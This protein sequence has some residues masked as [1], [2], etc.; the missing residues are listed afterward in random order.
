MKII[1]S[2]ALSIGLLAMLAM[3]ALAFD[4]SGTITTGGTAQ[5]VSLSSSSR[6]FIVMNTSANLMCISFDSVAAFGGTN[7]AVGSYPLAAGS[8]TTAGNSFT[9]PTNYSPSAF[10]IISSTT[11]DRFSC[12]RY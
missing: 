7:C 1:R 10:S 8:A 4:C 6:G 3:P 12:T 11:G 9:A 5:F 2:I